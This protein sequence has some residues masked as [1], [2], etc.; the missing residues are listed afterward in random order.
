MSEG[1]LNEDALLGGRVRIRQPTDG[2]RVAI[3]SVL[4]AAAVP[5][6]AGCHVLDA[7]AGVGGAALCL[8]ARV[9][10][11][12]V[13]GIEVDPELARVA[14]ENAALNALQARVTVI[15]GDILAP[16]PDLEPADYDHVMVNP[17][18]L[19]AGAA[20]P[21]PAPARAA[22]NVEGAAR[23]VDWAAFALR[24]V[25]PRGSVTFIHRAD[26]L[27]RLLLAI[28]GAGEV[29]TFP[30]WP[31]R[32]EAA[33][34]VLVR[35]RKGVRAPARLAFGLVLHEDDGSFTTEAEAVLREGKGLVL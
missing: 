2:F 28:E 7:G 12:R 29:T 11:C 4:L 22:A 24:M 21:S 25:K 35:A 17:P 20:R 5:A 9:P 32:G 27:D 14:R 1:R 13:T 16:P 8:A 18:Y 23:L 3:D 30:L 31:K 10:D 34:R 15:A 26:R 33:K 19:E 6:R